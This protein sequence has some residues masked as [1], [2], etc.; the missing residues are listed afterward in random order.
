MNIFQKLIGVVLSFTLMTLISGCGGGG[1]T[2]TASTGTA[3]L[4]LAD[5]PVDA[6]EVV[7][8]HVA[9]DAVHYK[10]AGSQWVVEELNET[11][12]INLL[13]LQDGNST[14]LTSQ[15]ELPTGRINQVRFVINYDASF[16]EL[17]ISNSITTQSL[18]VPSNEEKVVGGF[19]VPAGGDVN[20]TADFD[21]RKSLV[22]NGGNYKLKPTIKIVDNSQ[23]GEVSG[24]V[25]NVDGNTTVIIYAYTDGTFNDEEAEKLNDFANAATSSDATDGEYTLAWLT[26]GT[27][28]LVV[29]EFDVNGQNPTVLGTIQDVVITEDGKT[30]QDIDILNF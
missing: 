13:D 21:V 7:G 1:D 25:A 23:V 6:E 17:N 3:T 11:R 4:N 28:D 9:F 15:T 5:A 8:V 19:V 29:V 30:T 22:N 27:Y 10:P 2:T 18:N 12:V 20:I 16:I 26:A 14:L 24:T